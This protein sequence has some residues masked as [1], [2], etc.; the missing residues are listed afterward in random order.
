MEPRERI[1]IALISTPLLTTP[2]EFYGGLESVVADLGEALARMGSD[3][4]VFAAD[5]SRVEGCRVVELGPPELNVHA[6]VNWFEAERR[7]YLVYQQALDDF[8]IVNGHNWYGFEY[9]AKAKNKR[10]K[11]CH[12]HHGYGIQFTA[13]PLTTLGIDSRAF[14]KTGDL[15]L[16]LKDLRLL[17]GM[18]RLNLIA[19]SKWMTQVYKSQGFESKYVYNGISLERYAF[20]KKKGDRLLF[21]GRIDPEKQPHVSIQVAKR[22]N[23]GLD[24]V[25]GTAV[26]AREDIAYLEKIQKMCDGKQIKFY[27]DASHEL[28]TRLMQ[29]AKCVLFTSAWGEPFGLVPIEAMACGTPVVALND[30]AV[31]EVVQEGGIVCNILQQVIL[32]GGRVLTPKYDAIDAL[33]QAVK[34]I[35]SIDPQSCRKNAEKFSSDRMAQCYQRLY[36]EILAGEEW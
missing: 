9:V 19:I 10:L 21:V 14:L 15:G 2:P 8:D 34:K 33:A 31:E 3:V 28:K 20:Q 18:Y 30:G 12:T 7:A 23:T 17:T 26:R 6:H 32:S 16:I 13:R 25:G 5:G 29:N 1:K 24:I 35:D 4:T 27:P 36:T 22:L 11:I